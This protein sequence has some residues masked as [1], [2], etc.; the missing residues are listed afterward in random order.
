MTCRLMRV[1]LIIATMWIAAC[2]SSSPDAPDNPADPFAG[3]WSGPIT[4][5]DSGNGTLRFELAAGP[6]GAVSGNWTATFSNPANNNGGAVA[7]TVALPPPLVFT[8]QCTQSGRGIAAFTMSATDNR[9]MTG[10]YSGITCNGLLRG[11]TALAKQ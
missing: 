5:Q 7:S 6:A 11:T 9:M 2:D 1:G 4:D 10:T 3:V 8:A